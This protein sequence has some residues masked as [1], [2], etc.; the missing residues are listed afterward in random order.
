MLGLNNA[1]SRLVSLP[2]GVILDLVFPLLT[3]KD[4][5]SLRLV[6][7]YW[8]SLVDDEVTWRRRIAGS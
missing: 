4:L 6:S 8:K 3:A 2:P 1:P 5:C 7:N